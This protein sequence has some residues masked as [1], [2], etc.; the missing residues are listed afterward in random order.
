ME[1][2]KIMTDNNRKIGDIIRKLMKNPKLA[3]KLEKLD[4]LDAWNEIIGEPLTKY[5]TEQK[6]YKDMLYVK[7]KS[8]VVRNE[9]S[10]RK[11]E[12]ISEINKKTGKKTITDIVFN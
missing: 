2:Q 9:L 1:N 10:Y 12:F 6:I 8:A 3:I 7:V 4:A 5:I 11:S